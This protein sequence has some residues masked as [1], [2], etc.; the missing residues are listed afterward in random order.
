VPGAGGA[1]AGAAAAD[2]DV[3]LLAAD[4]VAAL[5]ARERCV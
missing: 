3:P 2:A 1:E 5:A 4:V